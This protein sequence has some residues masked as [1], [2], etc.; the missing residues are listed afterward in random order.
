MRAQSVKSE[1]DDNLEQFQLLMER[2]KV[3][4]PTIFLFMSA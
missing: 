2:P 3:A 4:W 1:R